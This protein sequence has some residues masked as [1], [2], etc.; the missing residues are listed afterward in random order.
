MTE[1]AGGS[2]S[3]EYYPEVQDDANESVS[4]CNAYALHENELE[5]ILPSGSGKKWFGEKFRSGSPKTISINV[6]DYEPGVMLMF[7]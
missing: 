5:N 4:T 6:P 1:D 2:K 7:G 3:V